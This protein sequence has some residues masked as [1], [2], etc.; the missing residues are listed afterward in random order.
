MAT[1]ISFYLKNPFLC[2]IKLTKISTRPGVWDLGSRTPPPHQEPCTV[3]LPSFIYVFVSCWVSRLYVQ[4]LYRV[5]HAKLSYC[6]LDVSEIMEKF[7]VCYF[8]N[9]T[10]DERN[11]QSFLI[12]L[13]SLL[14]LC[15]VY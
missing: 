2:L 3:I 13:N 9:H 11:Q 6:T 12:G 14:I 15:H 4:E 1:F 7:N 8:G 5:C 10:K